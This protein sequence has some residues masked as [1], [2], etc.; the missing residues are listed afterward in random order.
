MS[1]PK[2]LTEDI[3]QSWIISEIECHAPVKGVDLALHL[4]TKAQTESYE[5]PHVEFMNSV[6]SRLTRFKKI[7]CV[8][9]VLA[10]M[11]YRAKVAYFPAGTKVKVLQE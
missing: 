11:P 6:L 8:E 7:V 10:T 1:A 5:F 9:Y 4:M 3:L 2:K